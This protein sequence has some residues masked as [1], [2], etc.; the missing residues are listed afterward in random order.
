MTVQSRIASRSRLPTHRRRP[1]RYRRGA[2]QLRR[3]R[4]A[5]PARID[6]G[7]NAM[8]TINDRDDFKALDPFFRIIEQGLDG[9]VDGGHFFEFLA[10]DVVFEFIITVPD[11]PRRVV[12][13]AP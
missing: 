10:E 13:R 6:V 3:M 8:T 2:D 4:P 7:G 5:H 1:D 12:G 9:L 11:Y